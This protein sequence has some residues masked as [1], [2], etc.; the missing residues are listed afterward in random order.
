LIRQLGVASAGWTAAA[1]APFRAVVGERTTQPAPKPL[2]RS[3]PEE[4]GMSSAA[5]L[6]FIHA[7]EQGAGAVH[8][9][10]L[11]RRGHV[12]TEGWWTPYAAREPHAVYSV[13]KSVLSVAAGLAVAEGR[14]SLDESVVH[15]FADKVPANPAA[16]L[17]AM[18]VRDLLRL[19]TGHRAED[20]GEFPY[21]SEADLVR[22]FLEIAVPDKPG[23]H[24]IY[25]E[26]AVY[27]LS[28]IIQKVTGRSALDYLRPRLFAPLGIPNPTW[29]ATADGTTLGASGLSLRTEELARFALLHLQHGRWLG[30]Q[31]IPAQ[32]VE[33]ATSLQTATGSDPDRDADQGYGYLIWRLR[34]GCYGGI[35]LLGQMCIVMPDHQAVLVITGAT[36]DP[37]SL[38]NLVWNRLL[39]AFKQRALPSNP[40]ANRAL[41][42]TLARLTLPTHSG[43]AASLALPSI[44]GRSYKFLENAQRIEAVALHPGPQGAGLA[45]EVAIAGT[46]Q[47]IA[48]RQGQWASATL[49]RQARGLVPMT[50]YL[51]GED[52][53]PIPIAVNGAWGS[54][55]S[56]S[57]TL[58]RYRTAFASTYE[59]RFSGDEL[60]LK[61]SSIGARDSDRARLVG[62][63]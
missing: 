23:T 31:L 42:A 60:S 48:C 36:T 19:T 47:R 29:W 41:T 63:A 20:L 28:A 8:S 4:Q 57:F 55:D 40:E 33:A 14:L 10:M 3:T 44:A 51:G 16:N 26:P 18:R 12:I 22:A 25:D 32:W 45:I 58:C 38:L 50:G 9:V 1:A 2:P 39:P 62:R 27:L 59:M 17:K 13:S 35:G 7:L 21:Q 5:L 54:A 34:H 30:R 52:E 43:E 61:S 11:V 46:V 37:Q 49:S 56:Y 6:D 24:F 53:G 15:A